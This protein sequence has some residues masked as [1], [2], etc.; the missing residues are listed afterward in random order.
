MGEVIPLRGR[1]ACRA[2][3]TRLCEISVQPEIAEDDGTYDE[4]TGTI[5]CDPC[6]VRAMRFSPSGRAL[7]HELD[8]SIAAA[9]IADADPIPPAA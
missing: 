6:Y 2:R 1:V 9:R 5:V 3:I 7:H 8:D 4:A